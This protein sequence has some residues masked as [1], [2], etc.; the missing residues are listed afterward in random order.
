MAWRWFSGFPD[1]ISLPCVMKQS[2][3]F[4]FLPGGA[5]TTVSHSHSAWVGGQ[6]LCRERPVVTVWAQGGRAAGPSSW[7][8][9]RERGREGEMVSLNRALVG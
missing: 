9:I 1:Q 3:A 6:G 7:Y 2:V 4:T 5:G 8:E